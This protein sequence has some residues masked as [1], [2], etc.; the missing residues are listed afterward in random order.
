MVFSSF[1]QNS[2]LS[3]GK[4]GA[5]FDFEHRFFEYFTQKAENARFG[6]KIAY[7]RDRETTL[8]TWL[9]TLKGLKMVE[10]RGLQVQKVYFLSVF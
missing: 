2:H 10:K 4:I 5:S 8:S 7:F 3:Q 6:V 9:K 1:A